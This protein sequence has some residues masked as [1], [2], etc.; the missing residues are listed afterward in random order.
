MV[1]KWRALT[2]FALCG[3][4]NSGSIA[5]Q[6]GGL[7]SQVPIRRG[8]LARPGLEAMFAGTIADFLS[9]CVAGILC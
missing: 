8:D 9:A 3:F 7:G 2:T 4:A 1:T 6:V 5:I